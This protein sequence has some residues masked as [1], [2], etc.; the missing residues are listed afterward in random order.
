MPSMKCSGMTAHKIPADSHLSG[1]G[2][3]M[4]AD[5]WET[6]AEEASGVKVHT[7]MC[8]YM[9]QPEVNSRC[10]PLSISTLIFEAGSLTE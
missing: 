3:V 10:L 4:L 7:D 6:E 8:T 1:D 9:W 5:S 2:N